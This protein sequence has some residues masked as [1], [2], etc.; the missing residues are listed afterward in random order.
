MQKKTQRPVQFEITE[1]TRDAVAA[2]IATAHLKPEQFLFPSRVSE[3][4]HLSTRQHSL[5]VGASVG[6]IGLDPTAYGTR[7]LRR[8]KATPIYRRT[9]NLRA[10]QLRLGH[11]K[12]ES[13]V[14]WSRRARRTSPLVRRTPRR[15]SA[16]GR[17][18]TIWQ[19]GRAPAI[20]AR[21]PKSRI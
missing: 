20:G 7:T 4:P 10:V 18:Y 5:M 15:F 14:R 13:T 6:S 19:D 17:T 1:Q 16:A 11:T 3:S 21:A 9:R 8:T 12:L 2:R